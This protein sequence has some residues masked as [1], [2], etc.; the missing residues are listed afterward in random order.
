M[1]RVSWRWECL[2]VIMAPE[3]SGG[4]GALNIT[5]IPDLFWH[6]GPLIHIFKGQNWLEKQR[7]L[8]GGIHSCTSC[9]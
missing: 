1:E 5:G 4:E 3:L 7:Q 8:T 2:A 9:T 6:M